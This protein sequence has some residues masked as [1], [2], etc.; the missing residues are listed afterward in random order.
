MRQL[1]IAE[2]DS[3][4]TSPSTS[5]PTSLIRSRP[6]RDALQ[7]RDSIDC[8]E[9]ETAVNA[10]APRVDG[11]IITL[12]R[13]VTALYVLVNDDYNY[14]RLTLKFCRCGQA[15]NAGVFTS[16]IANAKL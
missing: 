4:P 15:N 8:V 7:R 10:L 11:R 2:T 13:L 16:L 14:Q 6:D 5:P 3:P 12:T 9:M 1:S